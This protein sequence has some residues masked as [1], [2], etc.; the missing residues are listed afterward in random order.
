MA[1]IRATAMVWCS[2]RNVDESVAASA[3][4]LVVCYY[5]NPSKVN[6]NVR[7]GGGPEAPATAI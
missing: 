2:D 4:V 7:A 6:Q 1:L 5:Y 3:P